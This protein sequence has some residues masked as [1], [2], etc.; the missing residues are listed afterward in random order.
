M[1]KQVFKS[2]IMLGGQTVKT[3]TANEVCEFSG[4]FVNYIDAGDLCNCLGLPPN[5]ERN[6]ST[7]LLQAMGAGFE[8]VMGTYEAGGTSVDLTLWQPRDAFTFIVCYSIQGNKKAWEIL[9][10]LGCFTLEAE[11]EES[12]DYEIEG[13][14]E[15]ELG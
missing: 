10:Y 2:S 9:R 8:P 5:T 12:I 6:M 4:N 1:T 11:I 7:G 14:L 3:Y 15:V 13:E